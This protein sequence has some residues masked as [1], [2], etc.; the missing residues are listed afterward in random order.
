MQTDQCRF[1]QLVAENVTDVR[2]AFELW[3][4]LVDSGWL[5]KGL[6]TRVAAPRFNPLIPWSSALPIAVLGPAPLHRYNQKEI[7]ALSDGLEGRYS[8]RQTC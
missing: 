2:P 5:A 8:T 6:Y 1:T 3:L 7:E 4:N